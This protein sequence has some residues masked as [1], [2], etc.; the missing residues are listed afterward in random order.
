MTEG[1]QDLEGALLQQKL[2]RSCWKTNNENNKVGMV[3]WNT[4]Q[5]MR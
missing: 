2:E 4:S 5:I 3:L 1:K